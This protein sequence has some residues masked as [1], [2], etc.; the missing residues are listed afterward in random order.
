MGEQVYGHGILAFTAA[1]LRLSR[2]IIR[3]RLFRY[4]IAVVRRATTLSHLYYKYK[5]VLIIRMPFIYAPRFLR[6][7]RAPRTGKFCYAGLW[8]SANISSTHA[9]I[10]AVHILE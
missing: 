10:F 1:F 4:D 6:G 2:R 5:N 9:L 3:A 8:R 7:E